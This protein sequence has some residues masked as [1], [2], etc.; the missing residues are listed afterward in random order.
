MYAPENL[1]TQALNSYLQLMLMVGA[2]QLI[3]GANSEL[4]LAVCL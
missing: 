2:N 1:E 4:F 3:L